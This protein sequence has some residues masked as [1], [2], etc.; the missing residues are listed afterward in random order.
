M[1]DPAIV[2]SWLRDFSADLRTL[3]FRTADLLEETQAIEEC[4]RE[5][6][7]RG[8]HQANFLQEEAHVA[9]ARGDESRLFAEH[10]ETQGGEATDAAVALGAA[11]G[12]TSEQAQ[13][14]RALCKAELNK[15]EEWL[16]RAWQRERAAVATVEGRKQTLNQCDL[17]KEGA[18]T[19]FRLAESK[20]DSATGALEVV[21]SR[22]ETAKPVDLS[23]Y[24]KAVRSAREHLS[25]C[26][27]ELEEAIASRNAALEALRCAELELKAA[28]SDR[29]AA[30][31]R[32]AES[33]EALGRA[34][35]AV[36]LAD[37]AA[38]LLE[39]VH[40]EVEGLRFETTR[41]TEASKEACRN[42][43]SCVERTAEMQRE[44]DRGWG[45]FH[46]ASLHAQG[47]DR[48]G[49]AGRAY[50]QQARSDLEDRSQALTQFDQSNPSVN[51]P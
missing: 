36:N 22:S 34:E 38:Q 35:D 18:Q 16:G 19:E 6:L 30:E 40:K 7:E 44:T 12:E 42:A 49:E 27:G 1:T 9:L 51:M 31:R 45:S 11:T 41:A 33:K 17:Q 24:E 39:V 13:R 47:A 32:V 48:C 28:V 50:C 21:F 8:E 29:I 20:L 25:Q 2:V 43:A 3:Y 5:V 46:E 14:V 23:S 37:V 10:L 4:C 15:A 26:E